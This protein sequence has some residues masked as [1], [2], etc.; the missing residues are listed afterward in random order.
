MRKK[1]AGKKH[2]FDTDTKSG[3]EIIHFLHIGKAAGTQVR[4]LA[5]A[6]NAQQDDLHIIKHAHHVKFN[7]LPRKSRYFFSIRDPLSRFVSGFYSRKRKGQPRIYSE[8]S[9]HERR[10]FKNFEHAADLAESLFEST[11]RG[12]KASFAINSIRH[13]SQN[14]VDW[15]DRAGFFLK[16][17]PPVYIIRQEHFDTDWAGFLDRIGID[18]PIE[19]EADSVVSHRNDYTDIPPLTEKAKANLTAWYCQDIEFYRRCS[20]WIS[21]QQEMP[22]KHV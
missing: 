18:G 12:A 14:Q 16:V 6:L 21:I 4:H 2:Q 10:A 17:R 7:D 13:T 11:P 5:Q 22:P 20:K 1:N 3:S 15:F 8:W 19:T 9:A